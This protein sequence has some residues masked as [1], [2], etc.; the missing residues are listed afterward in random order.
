MTCQLY[1]FAV[2]ATR[3]VR[4]PLTYG[5]ERSTAHPSGSAPDTRD[6]GTPAGRGT[7]MRGATS[8]LYASSICV[9]TAIATAAGTTAAFFGAID[10]AG[11]YPVALLWGLCPPLMAL[12]LR[13]RE[14]S[15][16]VAEE[17]SAYT[18][19]CTSTPPPHR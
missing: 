15:K 3:R 11:A 18:P 5:R 2:D 12:R 13:A 10:L 17:D 8:L 1:T 4:H 19:D 16:G 9:P 7:S 14:R 6:Q